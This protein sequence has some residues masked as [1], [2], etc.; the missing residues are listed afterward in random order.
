[1]DLSHDLGD[2]WC[3]LQATEWIGASAA[4]RG[5][6]EEAVRLHREGLQMAEQ[7]GLWPDVS[8]RLC[9]LGWIAMQRCDYRSARELCGQGLRLAT[10]QGS[11]LGVVFA[12]LGLAFAARRDGDLDAA[13]ALLHNLLTTAARQT[14]GAGDGQPLYL[15]S[16]LVELGYLEELRGDTAAAAAHHSRAFTIS[17]QLGAARDAAQALGGLGGA[18]AVSD[19]ERAALLIG[20]SAAARE[21]TQTRLSPSD[22]CDLDRALTAVRTALGRAAFTAAFNRGRNLSPH[23]AFAQWADGR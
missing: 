4:L 7:L 18:C 3:L 9:W 2:G 17:E 14:D 22:Q 15:P 6:Y 16:V 23:E 1:M 13:E 5:E 12:Q 8:G 20:A 21:E 11:P 19:P 10:E